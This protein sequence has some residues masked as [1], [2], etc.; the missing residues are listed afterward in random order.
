M[1]RKQTLHQLLLECGAQCELDELWWLFNSQDLVKSVT[2]NSGVILGDQRLEIHPDEGPLTPLSNNE[3]D[4]EILTLGRFLV[5]RP[6]T[7]ARPQ[8]IQALEVT[9]NQRH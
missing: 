9:T 6:H 8:R 1:I 5:D 7:V 4:L 2:Q 3:N